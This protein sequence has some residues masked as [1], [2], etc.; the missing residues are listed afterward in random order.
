[1][2]HV[3]QTSESG[4]TVMK[5]AAILCTLLA[6]NSGSDLTLPS[7]SVRFSA[8]C[9]KGQVEITANAATPNENTIVFKKLGLNLQEEEGKIASAEC[10]ITSTLA[11]KEGYRI[12]VSK[13]TAEADANVPDGKG[14]A[15]LFVN[16]G[17]NGEDLD[18]LSSFSRKDGKLLAEQSSFKEGECGQEAVLRSKLTVKGKKSE[19]TV[20]GKDEKGVWLLYSYTPC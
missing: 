2:R 11:G 14:F 17:F 7:P 12:G 16:H 19:I 8:D 1:M 6:G 15:S 3:V 9:E 13:F 10:T 18:G 4:G 20:G 5:I